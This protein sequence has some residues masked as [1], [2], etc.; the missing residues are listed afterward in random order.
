MAD[1]SRK[2]QKDYHE[3]P[4]DRAR[5]ERVDTFKYLGTWCWRPDSFSTC[6]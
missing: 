3:L 6:V 2:K 4:I 5:V 1:F